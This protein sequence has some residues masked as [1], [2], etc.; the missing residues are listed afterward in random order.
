[1]PIKMES[2]LKAQADKL[3]GKGKLRKKPSDSLKEAKD[4]FVYGTLTRMYKEG[5]IP[6]WGHFK[7]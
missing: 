3:A 1:V 6:A 4:R 2:A 7:K 5:K